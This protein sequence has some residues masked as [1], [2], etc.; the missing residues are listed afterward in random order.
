[1][2]RKP[3]FITILTAL[4]FVV[5]V[6]VMLYP[7]ISDWYVRRQLQQT[8]SQYN[9]VAETEQADY[10]EMWKGAEE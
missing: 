4:L 6:G 10:S 8:L 9:T 2:R 1:M 3:K 5:G 7:R